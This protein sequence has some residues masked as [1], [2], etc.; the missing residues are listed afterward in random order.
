MVKAFEL[1]TETVAFVFQVFEYRGEIGH[2][3]ILT[4]YS[5]R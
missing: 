4:G 1:S 3:E 2:G 5:W